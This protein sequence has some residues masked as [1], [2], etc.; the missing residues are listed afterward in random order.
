MMFFCFSKK[1]MT[2]TDIDVDVYKT[3]NE[4]II[5]GLYFSFIGQ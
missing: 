3:N 2:D 5:N 4:I 1:V